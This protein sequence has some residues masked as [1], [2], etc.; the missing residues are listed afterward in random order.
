MA[1]EATPGIDAA[2][3]GIGGLTV[4]VPVILAPMAGYTDSALRSLCLEFGCGM[5]F[6]EVTNAAGLVHGS[7]QT[8][9]LLEA[10]PGERPLAAHLYGNDPNVLARAAAAAEQ[11][12]RFDLIDI[13]C[14]CPVRRIVA[15]GCGAALLRDP[16]RIE[17]IVRAVKGAVAL[18]VTVK[19][20][21]G[22]EPGEPLVFDVARAAEAGGADA[23]IV[24]ARFVAQRHGGVADWDALA[25]LKQCCSIPVVGNGGVDRAADAPRMLA[26]TGVDAVMI[27]RAAVGAPW[28]FAQVNALLSGADWEPPSAAARRDVI[29]LH[30]ERLIALKGLEQRYRKRGRYGARQAAALHF[31][32]HLAQYLAGYPGWRRVLRGLQ[33]MNTPE[34][35]MTVVDRVL[36]AGCRIPDTGGLPG[37]L[38]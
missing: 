24:H 3:L 38:S 8:R 18:P 21:L 20:R 22:T 32:A 4:P 2:P 5:A 26:Q 34:A 29:A 31:R 9:H 17:R 7:G 14:G 23:V 11:M 33:E 28:I 13:N 6:T 30:L 15:K 27:G 10:R 16:A 12:S 1:E 35:V 25:R 36:G 37:S 19:T